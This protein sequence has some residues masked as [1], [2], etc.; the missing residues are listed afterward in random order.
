M[1]MK[2]TSGST[3]INGWFWLH[4]GMMMVAATVAVASIPGNAR[5][6]EDQF[7]AFE[8]VEFEKQFPGSLPLGF[9]GFDADVQM[10]HELEALEALEHAS[11]LSQAEDSKI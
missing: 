6:D 4:V 10:G 1:K 8:E 2:S 9:S 7:P 5:A 11:A 3:G